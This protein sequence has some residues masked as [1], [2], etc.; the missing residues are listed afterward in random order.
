M[1]ALKKGHTSVVPRTIA[2]KLLAAFDFLESNS[3]N[4][5]LHSRNALPGGRQ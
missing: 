1:H 4:P 3:D 2:R 5:P